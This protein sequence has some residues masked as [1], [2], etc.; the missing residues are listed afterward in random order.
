MQE[1]VGTADR[2][3]RVAVGSAL[4]VGALGALRRGGGI[5]PGLVLAG[6]AIVLE[7]AVTRVCPLNAAFGLDTR[8]WR[9]FGR[10]VTES[11]AGTI[12]EAARRFAAAG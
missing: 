9:P 10:L 3:L 2:W 6:G 5:V 4:V 11:E 7:T 8:T 12:R 1:N